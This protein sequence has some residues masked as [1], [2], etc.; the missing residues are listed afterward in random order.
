[1]SATEGRRGVLVTG[2]AGFTGRYVGAA[3]EMAGRVVVAPSPSLD[4]LDP[5]GIADALV[6]LEFDEV[7]HLAGL[8]F[9][10]H[11]DPGELYRVNTVG[12]TALLEV[13]GCR[14][15]SLRRV[16]LASSA[17]VYGNSAASPIEETASLAPAGHYAASKA[18]MELLANGWRSRLPLVVSRPFNYTGV[19]QSSQ[20]LIPKIVDHF[21]RRAAVIELGN[22]HIS[23][24]FSDVRQ[25]AEIYCRLLDVPVG[26]T[27]N[28]CSG[29]AHSLNDVLGM[30]QAI[31]GHEIEVRVNP[32]FIRTDEVH[33]LSG[34][35]AKLNRL[36]GAVPM[37]PFVDTLRWMLEA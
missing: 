25:V 3:L 23:R 14:A 35:P 2:L 37:P 16:V 21:R 13:L 4:L 27:V 31:T 36:V 10:A 12:T 18:A 8:A 17:N 6:G 7:I 19:G 34:S 20:F 30:C 9:V 22:V 29:V 32:A 24:D 11:G 5:D 28:I 33:L 15:H 1:M 26:M